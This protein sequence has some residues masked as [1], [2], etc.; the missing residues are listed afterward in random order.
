MKHINRVMALVLLGCM[1][2]TLVPM[3]AAA[4]ETQTSLCDL[5]RESEYEYKVLQNSI[6]DSYGDQYV[7]NIVQFRAN[8]NAHARYDL[9]GA[10]TTFEG[11]IV[12]SDATDSRASIGVAIIADGEIVYSLS[13]YTRQMPS[14]EFSLDLS[15]VRTLEIRTAN[16]GSGDAFLCFAG[17]TLTK[18]QKPK[19]YFTWSYLGDLKVI[20]SRETSA[21]GALMMDTFGNLHGGYR[22]MYSTYGS[23]VLYNLNKE[24]VSFEGAIVTGEKTRNDAVMTVK[25]YLD[26]KLERTFTDI[27]RQTPI[28]EFT[29]DV[30]GV[31]VLKIE[32]T[33]QAGHDC[34]V[35][36]VDDVLKAH[37]HTPGEWVV[38]KEQTCVDEG[39]RVAYCTECGE[40]AKTEPIPANGHTADENWV[41]VQEVNCTRNG[42]E[43]LNCVVC[44]EEV[45]QRSI[46][47]IPHESDGTWELIQE[48]TC[49]K[50][51]KRQEIC[52]NCGKVMR[53]EALP[54]AEHSYGGWEKVSG[55]IWNTPIMKQQTCEVCGDYQT[56]EDNSTSWLKPMVTCV[57]IM[58]IGSVAA[59]GV[60][61]YMN[62]L[63]IHPSSVKQLFKKETL[64][65][66]DI[67][68]ILNK[69]DP[70]PET[71]SEE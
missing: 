24:Y 26:N 27:T 7:S 48:S 8:Y 23:Y 37:M 44:G 52:K 13:G 46:T 42:E 59:L 31:Q 9:N 51:G 40:L 29:L 22:Q 6:T 47:K 28:Q 35:Y 54:L 18:V 1:L 10:Y 34:Y 50:A 43:V 65:D 68:E 53:V 58:I 57:F 56:K 39:E 20:D 32:A 25:I 12:I 15:G 69:P 14:Q 38:E 55:S 19:E 67:D 5:H 60:T 61:L 41:V 11:T 49:D 17:T 33:K 30:T 71:Q 36:I 63:P 70:V 62:G 21:N 64:T 3:S 4:A 45:Q 16:F 66:E 2:L